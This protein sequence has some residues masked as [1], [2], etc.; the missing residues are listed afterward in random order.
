M[1]LDTYEDWAREE[2]LF[3]GSLMEKEGVMA[4]LANC[5]RYGEEEIREKA[6]YYPDVVEQFFHT[7]RRQR[8][9]LLGSIGDTED[10]HA[11][12]VVLLHQARSSLMMLEAL[13]KYGVSAGANPSKSMMIGQSAAALHAVAAGRPQLYPFAEDLPFGMS[14]EWFGLEEE[15]AEGRGVKQSARTSPA[16][17]RQPTKPKSRQR[18]PTS[19]GP[20]QEQSSPSDDV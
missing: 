11:V 5:L 4:I 1:D 8:A 20:G 19:G 12:L 9:K 14:L 13:C 3:I 2:C 6:G 16:R 15:Q 7:P 17:T 10:L 18:R